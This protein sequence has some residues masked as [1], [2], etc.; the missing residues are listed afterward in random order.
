MKGTHCRYGR[1]NSYREVITALEQ[2]ILLGSLPLENTASFLY[3][4]GLL[5]ISHCGADEEVE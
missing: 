4:G 3:V 5:I 1:T 2:T